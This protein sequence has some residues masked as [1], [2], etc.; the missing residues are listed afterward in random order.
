MSVV[1]DVNFSRKKIPANL[2]LGFKNGLDGRNRERKDVKPKCIIACSV[3]L[4]TTVSVPFLMSTFM[5]KIGNHLSI[6]IMSH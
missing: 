3:T 5:R 6:R 2:Y 1:K 4:D